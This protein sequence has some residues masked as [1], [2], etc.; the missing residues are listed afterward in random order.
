MS[1][2]QYPPP[3][4]PTPP[5]GAPQVPPPG[6]GGHPAPSIPQAPWPGARMPVARPGAVPLRPLGLGDLLD[7]A[8]KIVRHNAGATV[9]AAL[10]VSVVS[11]VI[12]LIVSVAVASSVD[13]TAWSD[14]NV[15]ATES[16]AIGMIIAVAGWVV[17]VVLQSIASLF[18]AAMCAHATRAG[19]LGRKITLREAWAGTRGHRW[20]L[21]VGGLFTGFVM[22]LSLG[23]AVTLVVVTA[24][25]GGAVAAVVAGIVAALAW[26]AFM[27]WFWVRVMTLLT[28]LI[29]LEKQGVLTSARRSLDLT[30]GHF[31]RLFGILLLVTVVLQFVV[32][33]VALPVQ[34]LGMIPSFTGASANVAF[35]AEAAGQGVALL[36]GTAMS[37][38]IVATFGAL[39]LV[40]LRMRKEA[41]DVELLQATSGASR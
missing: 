37:T 28:P 4:A 8:V 9:G 27:A 23:I 17:G 40:D 20:R 31:W 33:M 1:G 35:V 16:E 29:A 30:R 18:V 5:P 21:L 24:Y 32:G 12:P 11:L 15:A 3:G 38:P 36:L 19:V 34:L 22:M 41:F 14:D 2:P 10:L 25:A 7:A 39:L 26:M 6:S 13:L